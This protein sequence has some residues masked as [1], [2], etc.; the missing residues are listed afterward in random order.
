MLQ[1]YTS[2]CISLQYFF[3][4]LFPLF[5]GC[6]HYSTQALMVLV[7]LQKYCKFFLPSSPWIFRPLSGRIRIK[8]N[9]HPWKGA[10]HEKITLHPHPHPQRAP[11]VC[12]GPCCTNTQCGPAA[13]HGIFFVSLPR[14]ETAPSP[15]TLIPCLSYEGRG[16]GTD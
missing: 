3:S 8:R 11:L 15:S 5:L 14:K 13:P 6:L 12:H 9:K 16:K 7:I 10:I 1:Y 2:L 4:F